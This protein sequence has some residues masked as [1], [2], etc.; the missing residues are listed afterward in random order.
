LALLLVSA[1]AAQ[2][3]PTKVHFNR[4]IRPILSDRCFTCHGPDE[5]KREG[6]FRLD[7]RDSAVGE[8]DSGER[9]LVPGQ[10]DASALLARITAEDEF[11]LMPPPE[12]G[13]KL[14]DE[15]I[16]LLRRWIAEGAEYQGHWSFL[17]PERPPLPPVPDESRVGN[18]IDHF[19]FSRLQREGFEP[20][21]EADKRTLI[22]RVSF[23]VTG[24]PP[25]PDEIREFLNDESAD[26]Y[27]KL[28]DRLLASPRYGEQMARF[29]LDAARYGDTHGLHLD[30]YRSI[31]PYRDWVINAFNDNMPFDQFT[32]EQLAGDLLP[33]P[34][35]DQLVA[36]GFNRCHVTTSEGGSIAEEFL[37]RYAVDRV[38][39]T[40]TVWLGMTMGCAVCHE[41]KF[42][43]F[44][45]KE[46]YQLFAYFNSTA[47]NPM[48]GNKP[49]QPNIDLQARTR[50]QQE[51]LDRF[52]R[53]IAEAEAEIQS[54][55]AK[56]EY[57][58]PAEARP[59][60]APQPEELV[61][62]D[63]NVPPGAK[64]DG[65]T[66]WQWV[67]AN[68]HPVASG[69]RASKRT[70]TELS[71]HFFIAAN[72]PLEVGEGD[73]L[74]AHVF[75][76]P[77]NP[78]REI[79]LQLND[80]SWEHRAIWG[81]DLIAWG[82]PNSPSRRH[83]GSL[84]EAGKWV[85]L[86]FDAAQ[87]GLNPGAKINGWAFTQFA[88]TV[89][90]DRAGIVTVKVPALFDSQLAWE[91]AAKEN[92]KAMNLPGE[93]SAAL[94][95]EPADRTAEAQQT[96]R[97]HFL[98]YFHASSREIFAP[99]DKRIE[100]TKR[101]REQLTKEI[102]FTLV[103][104]ELPQPRPAHVLNRGNYDQKLEQV[105]RAVPACF[106]PLPEGAPNNRLGLAQWLVDPSNPLSARVTVN[107]F[108]QQYFGVGLVKTA[109]DFGSQGEFPSH[110]G[111]L[112]W[113]AVELIESGWDVK[114]MQRL[115][116]TSATYRQSSKVSGELHRRDPENRLLARGPRYRLDAETV[117]D[118]ALAVSGLL[119]ERL[120]G[121]SVKP[122]Q[123][124][125]LWKAVGYTSSNTANFTQDRGDK[126]YRR[127][128][129]TFWKRTSPPPTM[130]ILDAPNRETC[131]V[132]RERTNTPLAALALMNDVQFFEAARH[133]AQRMMKEGGQDVQDRAAYAFELA[134]ARV[135]SP[136]ELQVLVQQY[137]AHRD[138]FAG[139]TESAAKLLSVGDSPRDE[140]L[141]AVEH[142]AYTMV[143]NLI[144]NLDET[145][146]KR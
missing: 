123:P 20:A 27:Q 9:P 113:L 111:L 116:V 108:W 124:L 138:A 30:N 110:P 31:W 62:I 98:R 134:T 58:E 75:L 5:S 142:A 74:F 135:P 86:E 118:N 53:Q 59:P 1:P 127:S 50:S 93:V 130:S 114:H 96:L 115:I 57:R 49:Y 42:D 78:P 139:N 48:D 122:Y 21:P 37:V 128:L 90:W 120:G 141:D 107:R 94:I 25:T 71:Q 119:V 47:E 52:D 43:P 28:V 126:L 81:E 56:I 69:Q 105:Q 33:N 79:M 23:D 76:D 4:D 129:Y 54:A 40:S 11:E 61:W 84:P 6:G 88:G 80:G 22:R 41:H 91:A 117:R 26:A 12:T 46:F 140:S 32:I 133:L 65:N 83:L 18:A 24:L 39:T 146:T 67:T 60:G 34:T 82:T 99:L 132:R 103:S 137:Q 143:A 35:T 92:A 101:Q 106:P 85:R 55:L 8:A 145:V 14:A 63:D 112:D 44:S 17:K 72:P 10:P 19:V 97:N 89:Y 36:T 136:Q 95:I 13:K 77:D 104:K 121:P 45:Q 70:A 102:P 3:E 15:E 73:R 2:A 38:E 109:E 51:Q 68:E 131:T 7:Q 66:P 125:G 87:V 29:W 64:P 16:D 100:E 144:L